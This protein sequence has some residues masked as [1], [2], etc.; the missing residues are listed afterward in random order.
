M[1]CLKNDKTTNIKSGT[2]ELSLSP[3]A[4]SVILAG[5]QVALLC[6]A[7]AVD[8]TG[9]EGTVEDSC[10]GSG[11]ESGSNS[12]LGSDSCSGSVKNPLTL[13]EEKLS[14]SEYVFTWRG[15]SDLWDAKEYVIRALETHFEYSVR[16]RGRGKIDRVRYFIGDAA[17]ETPGSEYEFDT[18]FTPI[19]TV[20]GA[21]QCEF[22]AQTPYDEFS[23]LTIPPM[24]CYV[25]DVCGI[26]DK[27]AFALAAKRGG[28]QFTKFAY[29]TKSAKFLRR[30]WFWTDQCGHVTVDGE[31]ESPAVLVYG[32]PGRDEALKFYSDYY[33][34]TGI[35]RR[36]A[37]SPG[38]F[39][40]GPMACGWIEQA[41]Y[42]A[43]RGLDTPVADLATQEMYDNF[44]AELQRRGLHPK[45]MIIDDKWQTEYGNAYADESKW[46]D[47]R[48][49]IDENLRGND[50]H[51]MLWYKLW[52]SEGLPE[53]M[54]MAG[55]YGGRRVADPTNPRYREH[56]RETMHRLLSSD[57]GCYNAWGL[58]LDFAFFQPTGRE[59]ISHSG[60]YGVELL[61]EYITLIYDCA[62]AVKPEAV[63]SASPCHP[64]F[65]C[66]M[67]HARLHDY[68]PDLRRVYEEFSFRRN[69]YSIAL[70]DA[71]ID[72][73]GASFS[74][75][76][77]TMR[78]MR[79]VP[80]L[81]IPDLYC[82]T[83]LSSAALTD[84]DWAEASEIWRE[85]DRKIDKIF[86]GK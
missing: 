73:D 30:F 27:L 60:K 11:L 51:T 36:R 16:V 54:T 7:S 85:Y 19:P 2:Y 17:G 15:G 49:W 41:A 23:F 43:S 39:W 62:K 20:T 31:W 56:I 86:E 44:T 80:T 26:D 40:Y 45:I 77:D 9:A 84:S 57:E 46:P 59:A 76:R 72:T 6:P 14:D 52:D 79:L 66:C 25:F 38:R 74:S 35:A 37:L 53:D 10:S 48:R 75:R 22:S 32:T 78:H 21:S 34:D 68:H 18:G 81:G 13:T 12:G 67:D 65:S 55:G 83:P 70:P 5:E 3:D 8:M 50:C 42:G 61:L 24:F 1:I 4:I 47:L 58:K 64:L 33:Y 71:L 28:H 82:I 69:I 29:D 63:I